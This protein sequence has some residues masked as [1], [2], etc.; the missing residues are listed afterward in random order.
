[1]RLHSA[2]LHSAAV[3]CCTVAALA[4]PLSAPAAATTSATPTFPATTSATPTSA[5]I[6]DPA[7]HVDPFVGT[8][9]GGPDF[10]HG[11]GAGNTFP[12]A[13]APFGMLQWSPDTVTHQ[14]GGYHYDDNRIR[15]FSLTHLSGPGCSDFG[16][17][18]FMPSLGTSPAAYSTFAHADEQASPGY[19]SVRDRKS[20]R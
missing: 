14:H 15:G 7:Q 1:M 20:T 8:R 9:P 5:A 13:V 16:N 12:G 18:S 11:G 17:V 3:A 4:V 10:G 2:R 19:Y 6:T